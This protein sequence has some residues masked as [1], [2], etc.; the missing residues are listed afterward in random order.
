MK[1]IK[2]SK[3]IKP[4][5]LGYCILIDKNSKSYIAL[6]D[7]S[8]NMVVL[9]GNNKIDL[10]ESKKDAEETKKIIWI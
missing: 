1:N 4:E 9:Q 2:I 7:K 10:F 5:N 3:A 8:S 6:M